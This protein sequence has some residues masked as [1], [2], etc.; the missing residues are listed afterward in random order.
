MSRIGVKPVKKPEAVEVTVNGNLVE[1]KGPKG[2]LSQVIFDGLQVDVQADQVSVINPKPDNKRLKALHGL[3]RSIIANMVTGV[4]QG[5]QKKLKI[6]GTGYRASLQDKTLIL[7]VGFSHKVN[8]EV[9]EDIEVK[10]N[11]NTEIVVSGID[12][13]LVGQVAADIR[14]V[15]PPEPYKGK[16]IRYEDEVVRRKA[17]KA[18][19]A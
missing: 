12:K 3:L 8:L 19:K 6:V 17:G 4:S 1:V 16:G 2:Q 10:V 14:A 11:K 9:P 18:G 15:K 5:W 7:S 13:V